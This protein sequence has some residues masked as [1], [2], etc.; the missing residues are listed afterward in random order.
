M[1][2]L[3]LAVRSPRSEKG[4][5]KGKPIDTDCKASRLTAAGKNRS[6]TTVVTKRKDYLRGEGREKRSSSSTG[7]REKKR[8]AGYEKEKKGSSIS[9]FRKGE[10][11]QHEGTREEKDKESVWTKP[12]TLSRCREERENSSDPR[13]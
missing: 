9:T 13:W 5:R 6:G 3:F 11:D 1:K 2:G 12:R 7:K 4:R 10:G 8:A